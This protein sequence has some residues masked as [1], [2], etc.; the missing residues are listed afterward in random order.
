M[1]FWTRIPRR[2]LV[3]L[4]NVDDAPEVLELMEV[5]VIVGAV[6][7]YLAQ[8]LS[9]SEV[10]VLAQ[11]VVVLSSALGRRSRLQVV[12][13]PRA[14]IVEGARPEAQCYGVPVTP[15]PPY[16]GAVEQVAER[17][18]PLSGYGGYSASVE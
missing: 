13:H 18:L 15:Q 17:H 12:V 7:K 1:A 11:G 10:Q 9:Q 3:A 8:R 5:A 4:G 6:G 2:V 14:G 16:T